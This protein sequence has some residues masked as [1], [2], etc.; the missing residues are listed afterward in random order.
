MAPE[1]SEAAR[2]SG[3]AD[4]PAATPA[5]AATEGKTDAAAAS[6]DAG[7]SAEV[8][9]AV[10]VNAA[11]TDGGAS[12]APADASVEDADLEVALPKAVDPAHAFEAARDLVQQ[13][14]GSLDRMKAGREATTE[15]GVVSQD[16][17]ITARDIQL[18]ILALRRA[19][20][21]S[22]AAAESGRLAEMQAR[23]VADAEF[24]HLETR[25]YETACTH[26]AARRFRAAPTPQ[27]SKLR[28]CL[29][30]ED[31]TERKAGV[32]EQ[33]EDD[34]DEVIP[35]NDGNAAVCR[36]SAR[37]QAEERER[38]RLEERLAE[39]HR[40]RLAELALLRDRENLGTELATR[41]RAVERALEPV[42]DLLELKARP[43]VQ[44]AA[45]AAS[46]AALPDPLRLVYSK[47]DVLASFGAE[48]GIQLRIEGSADGAAEEP[49]AKR[50]RV[51]ANSGAST[52]NSL[53]A[54]SAGA[55]VCV[56]VR[57]V[58]T[59]AAAQD[60]AASV[61]LRF[62]CPKPP[63]VTVSIEV[64]SGVSECI[65]D[66]LWAGDDGNGPL[67]K[68]VGEEVSYGKPFGWAQV[69]AGSRE[70]A[71]ALA[72]ATFASLDGGVT[73]SDVVRLI[74]ERL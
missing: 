54:V 13:L 68:A 7:A 26:A 18:Q 59:G 38:T 20:R 30:R 37:L 56:E 17:K 61:T 49:L 22:A 48:S 44:D 6:K 10:A 31:G 36:L 33:E 46:L 15:D 11:A 52:S 14:H 71:M 39:L 16:V 74:R 69:L 63:L 47:F 60:V 21:A 53:A 5:P 1:A 73:A 62:M 64:S 19:H 32:D 27:L 57:G 12:V 23:K 66:S 51:D 55:S 42:C 65:L 35:A 2:P 40:E 9:D 70:T 24:A 3:D 4:P 58:A 25:K 8:S 67:A 28:S 45:I 34:E 29:L 43:S 50:A 72:P 41:L